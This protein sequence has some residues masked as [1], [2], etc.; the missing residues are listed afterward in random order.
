M[1]HHLDQTPKTPYRGGLSKQW[2]LSTLRYSVPTVLGVQPLLYIK[3]L[4]FPFR[5]SWTLLGGALTLL[6]RNLMTVQLKVKIT[7]QKV[8]LIASAHNGSPFIFIHFS[9]VHVHYKCCD[10][11]VVIIWSHA[12]HVHLARVTMKCPLC[13]PLWYEL[14]ELYVASSF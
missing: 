3:L 5:R 8:S 11:V 9:L 1:R 14:P 10:R 13:L 6:F 7:L 4:M 12:I 2:K